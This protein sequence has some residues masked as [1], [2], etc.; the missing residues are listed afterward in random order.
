MGSREVTMEI[1]YAAVFALVQAG[2]ESVA[3][4]C[5]LLQIS[6]KSKSYY[7]YLARFCSEGLEGLH[8][9]RVGR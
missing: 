5:D 9:G 3:S 7:K 6:R 1:K 8:R 2:G 4:V